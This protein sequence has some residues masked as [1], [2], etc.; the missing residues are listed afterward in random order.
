MVLSSEIL[1]V[2]SKRLY[3]LEDNYYFSR[4]IYNGSLTMR[5][6]LVRDVLD[7][8]VKLFTS[9]EYAAVLTPNIRREAAIRAGN[10]VRCHCEE[11]GDT[12]F[13]FEKHCK[14]LFDLGKSV[15]GL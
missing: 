1:G 14:G 9:K 7:E 3:R 4:L 2:Y 11:T 15:K 12:Y 8:F 13:M 10:V 6:V 5:R